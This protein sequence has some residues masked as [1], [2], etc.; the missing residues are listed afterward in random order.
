MAL[1]GD[2]HGHWN[3]HDVEYFSRADYDLML[4][5]GDLGSGTLKNG[6][7]VIRDIA[8][9]RSVGLVLAGNNDAE[10]LGPL[11]AELAHQSGTDALMRF[12]GV[13]PSSSL[14]PCGYSKHQLF[15]DQGLVTLIA[16]R[17]AAMGGSQLSFPAELERN[18]GIS[19]LDES[20]ALLKQLV[21]ES[22]TSAIAFL[23]HNGPFGL[24]GNTADLWARD[25]SLPRSNDS[26]PPWDWGDSDLE[27]A[28]VYAKSKGKRVLAV[29]AGHM[30]RGP[31][32]QRRL[33]TVD[34]E[35][36]YVNPAVVPR[37]VDS[38]DGQLHHFVEMSLA[39]AAGS[40][41][42]RVSVQERWI[43]L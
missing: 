21:D 12:S 38:E 24:G 40:P 39:P 37:I 16:A 2:L 34:D 17:P 35:T 14:E 11:S 27:Q 19:S 25:F 6:L 9:V 10:H 5:V 15:T 33:C 28:I 1:I 4:F 36:V 23:A 42:E 20:A 8:K 29:I 18:Y 22:S 30:H 13:T 31:K 3:S 26:D 41:S 7:A 32:S 43:A